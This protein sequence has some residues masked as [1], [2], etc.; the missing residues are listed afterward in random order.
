ME[1][2]K[3]FF[4]IVFLFVSV[5]FFTSL[6]MN[7]PGPVWAGEPDAGQALADD[8][9]EVADARADRPEAL[10]ARRHDRQRARGPARDEVH[11]LER[12]IRR[13]RRDDRAGIYKS[14]A[15]G[16]F[17]CRNSGRSAYTRN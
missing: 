11:L 6:K 7:S 16:F 2:I 13:R 10:P 4:L 15:S 14:V 5:T 3:S 1:N 8:L 9:G 12:R 17:A